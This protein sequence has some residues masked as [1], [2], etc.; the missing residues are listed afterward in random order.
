MEDTYRKKIDWV[1]IVLMVVLIAYSLF[2][3]VLMLWG[4]ATSLKSREEFYD[5]ALWFPRG[6]IGSWAWGNYSFVWKNF[7]VETFDS[8]GRKISIDIYGQFLNT[9]LYAIGGAFLTTLCCCIVAYLSA[10]FKYWFSSIVYTIVLITM[11]V[12]T[13]GTTPAMLKFLKL[14]NLYD[15]WLGAYL[16]KFSFLS[17]YFLIFHG[18]FKGI[19][20]EYS[21]AATIDGANEYQIFFRINLP[22]VTTTFYTV[23]LIQFIGYWNDYMTALLYLPTHPTLA[24]GV[25]YMSISNMNR[26]AQ[27]PMRMVACV[28]LALPITC[29]FVIFRNKVM[30]NVTMGGIKE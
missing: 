8:L 7:A 18:I 1:N 3:V 15:S 10:K 9:L 23:F 14:T 12:P 17:L 27:T 21:E 11:V 22:L 2:L 19:S 25:Y 4:V 24:Y 30:G 20:P 5:N 16:M 29:V 6:N 13:I 28:I 26:L